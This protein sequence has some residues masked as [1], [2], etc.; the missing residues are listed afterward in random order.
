MFNFVQGMK[1]I[2]LLQ[3]NEYQSDFSK[4]LRRSFGRELH[5]RFLINIFN[6]D[7]QVINNRFYNDMK[8]EFNKFKKFLPQNAENI[9]DI[10]CGIG[11]IE[12]CDHI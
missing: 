4:Y 7:I 2:L 12:T 11:A 9:L 10:G 8:N 6:K 3:R 5:T 1:K